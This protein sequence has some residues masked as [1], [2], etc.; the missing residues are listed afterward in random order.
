MD[1]QGR[2]P[3]RRRSDLLV[4]LNARAGRRPDRSGRARTPRCKVYH[5]NA[6]K[7]H[8]Q[9]SRT[10]MDTRRQRVAQA[11][12]CRGGGRGPFAGAG[13]GAR[14]ELPSSCRRCSF[15][16]HYL[17]GRSR[18]RILF[19]MHR[20]Y[21]RLGSRTEFAGRWGTPQHAVTLGARAAPAGGLCVAQFLPAFG[22]LLHRAGHRAATTARTSRVCCYHTSSRG[23]FDHDRANQ[24]AQRRPLAACSTASTTPRSRV[25]SRTI[26]STY[27]RRSCRPYRAQDGLRVF[28]RKPAP[29][30]I[31]VARL[32]RHDGACVRWITA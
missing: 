13:A 16:S 28:A 25:S 6:A 27:P 4:R 12:A 8:P 17:A 30:Q 7:A 5:R 23:R 18:P 32:S 10:A 2:K 3:S 21:G 19:E 9:R 14:L 26:A 31:D 1:T 20:R 24:G 29:V 11:V 22:R 15:E